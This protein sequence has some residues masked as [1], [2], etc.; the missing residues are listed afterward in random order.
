MKLCIPIRAKSENELF[1]FLKKTA[2]KKPDLLEIWL[3]D[4]RS[5]DI[6][7][8]IHT[9]KIPLI[10][11][12][13]SKTD[14]KNLLDAIK[15]KAAYIDLDVNKTSN[16][17]MKIIMTQKRKAK[18]ILSYHNFQ[19]TPSITQL[20]KII[21]KIFDLRADI[22]KIATMIKTENDNKKLLF[23][24]KKIK[25]TGK[26]VII[27]SMGE[28][29]KKARMEAARSGSEIAYAA[30]D[31]KHMTAKGQWTIDDWRRN[32]NLCQPKEL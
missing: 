2:Q 4:L 30:L 19:K 20:E 23:L 1:A 5:P 21:K 14:K 28:K 3:D 18:I 26:K 9:A 11:L 16:S 15:F 24:L 27:H 7:K 17:A 6:K 25:K 13:R 29:G 22:A 31:E 12:N 32:W 10:F 8:I